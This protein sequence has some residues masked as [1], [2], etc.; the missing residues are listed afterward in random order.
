M[1]P[2]GVGAEEAQ[3]VDE[4]AYTGSPFLIGENLRI[5]QPGMVID[6]EVEIFPSGTA[7]FALADAG[8]GDA[9]ADAVD[10][11]QPFNVDMDHVAGVIFFVADNRFFWIKIFEPAQSQLSA[12]PCD[13]CGRQ[14]DP[15]CNL[16]ARQTL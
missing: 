1:N 3:S 13:R 4:E 14:A 12:H 7:L 5:S 11:P 6:S 8:T 10:P 9:V 2:D 16:P 15:A